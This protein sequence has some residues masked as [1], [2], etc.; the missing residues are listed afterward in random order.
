MT[1]RQILCEH[2]LRI[3]FN[4]LMIEETSQMLSLVQRAFCKVGFLWMFKAIIE[5][6]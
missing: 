1:A 6:R 3:L 4:S 5:Q 2:V